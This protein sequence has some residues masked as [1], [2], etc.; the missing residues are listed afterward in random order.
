[1]IQN[2]NLSC[3]P[4]WENINEQ[5]HRRSYAFGD[6][7]PLYVPYGYLLPF[8]VVV[9]SS[10]TAM[11]LSLYTKDG[12]PVSSTLPVYAT[13]KQFTGFN[14]AYG[15]GGLGG[16]TAE[17]QYYATLSGGGVTLYS[18]VFTVVADITPYLK[19][20]WWFDDD[21]VM[22]GAAVIG[23]LH[24][25]VYLNSQ[26][27][28]PEYEFEEE[29]E[30]RDGLFFPE[31]MISEKTY[32]FQFLANEPLCDVMR[33]VRMADH[34]KITDRYSN[35]YTADTFLMTPKWETQGNIASVEAEF[36]TAI[37][38]KRIGRSYTNLT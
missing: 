27:G 35:V 24:N 20:E 5:S 18:D 7:Y 30:K 8:N 17:G 34:I 22:D 23:S 38:A 32:K 15:A 25:Y 2:N 13:I 3:L 31:K 10:V 29:G 33:L 4:F 6:V 21:L 16:I 37:I 36:Q 14:V 1:M 11:T 12:T 9:P 19:V 26:L 28:K